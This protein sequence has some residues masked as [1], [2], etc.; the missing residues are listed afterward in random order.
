M[1]T[2][3]EWIDKLLSEAQKRTPFR[4]MSTYDPDGDCFEF[5]VSDEPF[6]AERLDKWVTVYY[7]RVSKDVVGSLICARRATCAGSRTRRC[8]R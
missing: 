1:S 6:R 2:R 7:G 8:V 3:E 5:F 4:P